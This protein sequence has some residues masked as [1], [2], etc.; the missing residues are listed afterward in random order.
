MIF[1]FCFVISVIQTVITFG[2]KIQL[3]FTVMLLMAVLST[4]YHRFVWFG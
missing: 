2:S 3:A 1:F 4:P